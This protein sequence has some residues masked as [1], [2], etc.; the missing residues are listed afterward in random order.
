MNGTPSV[1]R[2]L[3]FVGDMMAPL[4]S[5]T[6]ARAEAGS[7]KRRFCKP[8]PTQFRRDDFMYREIT[9]EGNAAIY[10]Q[11]WTG[12]VEPSV[13][14]EVIRIRRRDGFQIGGRFVVAAFG[15]GL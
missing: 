3:A 1:K 8:L 13:C 5:K 4:T 7:E 6:V 11:Y 9:R 2:A 10:E 14:S 15:H 12:R